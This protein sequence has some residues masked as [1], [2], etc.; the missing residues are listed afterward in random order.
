MDPV[1]RILGKSLFK[2][3]NDWDYDGVKDKRDCQP[4]NPLRQDDI[5]EKERK[6]AE[7]KE[8]VIARR[9]VR[10]RLKRG[11]KIES[12]PI[13]IREK[14]NI[15]PYAYNEE[16][17]NYKVTKQDAFSLASDYAS[18][19]R[20]YRHNAK[21]VLKKDRFGVPYYSVMMYNQ[22]DTRI[23]FEVLEL[24]FINST[25]PFRRK[26]ANEITSFQVTPYNEISVYWNR[27]VRR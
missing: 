21:T 26:I 22:E 6:R 5:F 14:A 24:V 3:K 15:Y 25:N 27:L 9:E 23:P 7:H 11:D 12:I 8:A 19:L 1:K 2:G 18:V 13:S 20:R 10:K 16:E 4:Y 17:R